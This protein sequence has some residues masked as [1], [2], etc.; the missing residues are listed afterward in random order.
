MD[1][2]SPICEIS[3]TNPIPSCLLSQF[4]ITIVVLLAFEAIIKAH[5]AQFYTPLT[6]ERPAPGIIFHGIER[7]HADNNLLSC[8]KYFTN[9]L[10][11][12]FGLEVCTAAIDLLLLFSPVAI[13]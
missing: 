3:L 10:F 9:Y 6:Q 12:K 4:Y 5:Q 8:I 7:K 13:M 2:A 1:F 11:Y